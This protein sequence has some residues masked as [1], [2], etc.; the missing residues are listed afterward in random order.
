MRQHRALALVSIFA[1]PFLAV[2]NADFPDYEREVRLA[3]EAEAGLFEGDIV[4]LGAGDRE[5]IAILT[6]SALGEANGAVVIM[7][8]RGFHPDW[9]EVANPVRVG[10]S[11]SGWTTLSI[12]M[13]VLKKDATYYEY[14]PILPLSHPR[15]KA[16]IEY[17]R[18]EGYDWVALVAHS[19]SVHM[20]M[21][22]LGEH[23]DSSIDAFV[24]IGMGATDFGQPMPEPFPIE[25]L[26][27]PILD[28]FGSEDYPA[29]VAKAPER[30]EALSAGHPDSAQV[31]IDGPDHFFV[32]HE[33][34]LISVISQ[35]L[36]QVR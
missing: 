36:G 17:L 21:S 25:R 7:H 11:E 23:G 32:D 31:A 10:L 18:T 16:A 19:C 4:H 26:T 24:G 5:F 6:E 9:P 13:P 1:M 3:E 33:G 12:Q 15:I 20:T 14:L 2:A 8:G 30:L 34:E 28:V 22:W 29:V 27:I 35:W